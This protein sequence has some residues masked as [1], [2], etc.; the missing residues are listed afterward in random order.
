[1]SNVPDIILTNGVLSEV[2][3]PQ[4]G[5]GTFQ[6]PRAETA[7]AVRD[8]LS[9]GYRHIDTAQMY[10]NEAG[11]AE[12]VRSSGLGRDEVFLTTKLNN[13][14]HRRDAAMRATD[15]SLKALGVDQ[16]DLYL[17]HWPLPTIGI[18]YVE[19]WKA[20]IEILHDGK[21]R[22]IGV[23]NF[24]PAH[25]ERII[26]ETGVVPA[27]N[28]VQVHPYSPNNVCRDADLEYGIATEAWAPLAKGRVL[29]E[30]IVAEIAERTG[31]TPSQ[32]VLRW[33]L[34]RG[35]IVIPK[36]V[37]KT[38]MVQNFELFDFE[39]PDDDMAAIS[40]LDKGL[41]ADPDPNTF[42]Y[43]PPGD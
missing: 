23:S 25:L 4:L 2:A 39:L 10:G 24:M 12:A 26:G 20:M 35:D 43:I 15:A 31:R 1:M 3:I 32:V 17:I 29:A 27:A 37:H 36:S 38:R 21:A 30:P 42:D 6:I 18:D 7:A 11:V 13:Q 33:H 5:F 9:V 41:A 34:Q 8:A 28:Q 19:T 22:A 16:I 14:Y 40:S